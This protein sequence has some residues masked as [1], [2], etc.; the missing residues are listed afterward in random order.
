MEPRIFKFGTKCEW[1]HEEIL[2]SCLVCCLSPKILTQK[3]ILVVVCKTRICTILCPRPQ[4]ILLSLTETGFCS[5][6]VEV[7]RDHLDYFLLDLFVQGCCLTLCIAGSPSLISDTVTE[8]RRLGEAISPTMA[9][10]TFGI[11]IEAQRYGRYHLY[12]FLVWCVC[13]RVLPNSNQP[14]LTL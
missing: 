6:V 1:N 5:C 4:T 13:F 3:M 7:C 14:S 10:R 11:N 12:Y 2:N 9:R 8:Y